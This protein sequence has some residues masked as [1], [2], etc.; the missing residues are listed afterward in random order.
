M[1]QPN[2]NNKPT[3]A[4]LPAPVQNP[5]V[6]PLPSNDTESES[7]TDPSTDTPSAP[8]MQPPSTNKI[9]SHLN[10]LVEDQKAA[11]SINSNAF[12]SGGAIFRDR[13][14]LEKHL[15]ES[16]EEPSSGWESVESPFKSVGIKIVFG[17]SNLI[18]ISRNE[19][20]IALSAGDEIYDNNPNEF[21]DNGIYKYNIDT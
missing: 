5:N 14:L 17:G 4:P 12:K 21:K 6:A 2:D 10:E 20:I 8:P 16:V 1:A 3:P 7:K 15:K 19:F 18:Q 9:T 11:S 13:K